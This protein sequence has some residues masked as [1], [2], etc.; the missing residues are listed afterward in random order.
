MYRGLIAGCAGLALALSASAARADFRVCNH[1]RFPT[2]A[3]VAY[4]DPNKG[5]VSSGWWELEKLRCEILITGSV[6]GKDIYY[7]A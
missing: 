3:A 4:D 1:A 6:K 7:F 2:F 5:W